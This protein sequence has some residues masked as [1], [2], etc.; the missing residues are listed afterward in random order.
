MDVCFY[1]S[2]HK[3]NESDNYKLFSVDIDENSKNAA[4]LLK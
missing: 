2:K 4:A 3:Y 1:H